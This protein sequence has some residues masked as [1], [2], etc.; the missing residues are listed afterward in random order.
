MIAA[1]RVETDNAQ[2][3]L[4]PGR[5]DSATRPGDGAEG[6]VEGRTLIGT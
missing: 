2:T 3:A 5:Q 1:A 4:E 6:V